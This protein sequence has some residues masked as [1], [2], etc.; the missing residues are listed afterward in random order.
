MVQCDLEPL[1]FVRQIMAMIAVSGRP[2]PDVVLDVVEQLVDIVQ[3]LSDVVFVVR[4][5]VDVIMGEIVDV[6]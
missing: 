2:I 4:P 6:N 1:H 3:I 5:M